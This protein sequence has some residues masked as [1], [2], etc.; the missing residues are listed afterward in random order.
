MGIE[1]FVLNETSYFG[2]GARKVL[3]EEIKKRGF[4]KGS[5]Q[6]KRSVN[7]RRLRFGN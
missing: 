6:I 2:E 4:K 5:K 1:K 3:P 7:R